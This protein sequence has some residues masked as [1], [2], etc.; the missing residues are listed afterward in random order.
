MVLIFRHIFD[1]VNIKHA[2]NNDV[3]M[4]EFL[5]EMKDLT[6]VEPPSG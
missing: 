3:I 4:G 6:A 2:M 1:I 5:A